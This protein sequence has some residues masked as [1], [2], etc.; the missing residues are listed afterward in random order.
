NE[1]CGIEDAATSG[2]DGEVVT[3][4]AVTPD[5]VL[6]KDEGFSAEDLSLA[7]TAAPREAE[8]SDD[9]AGLLENDLLDRVAK[10]PVAIGR[11]AAVA[12]DIDMMLSN[13]SS[14]ASV[15]SEGP[16]GTP[17]GVDQLPLAKAALPEVE[18]V[19]VISTAETVDM[20]ARAG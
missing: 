3:S 2:G 6:D 7:P 8:V 14:E 18:A 9:M 13:S 15:L 17:Q 4:F 11:R 16:D 12:S 1:L 20:S 5:D 10:P 19:E